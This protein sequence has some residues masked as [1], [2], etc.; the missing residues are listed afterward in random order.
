MAEPLTELD[1]FLLKQWGDA[2]ALREALTELEERLSD[3]LRGVADRLPPWLEARGFVLHDVEAR[4][5]CINVGK[6][7]W[8]N[9]DGGTRIYISIAA[10]Y[11]FGFRKNQEEHPYV[12]VYTYGLSKTEQKAFRDAAVK[13]IGEKPGYWINDDCS[14]K[15]PVGRYIR[16]HGDAERV[17]LALSEDALEAFVKDQLE[18]LLEISSELDAALSEV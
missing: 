5:S 1:T 4:Y 2:S 11:P 13:R 14:Q 12:W 6:K 8:M 9:E 15:A 3:R 10:L 7:A 16:S 17:Q 18:P